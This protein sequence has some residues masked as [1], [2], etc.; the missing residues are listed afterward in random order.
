M[1]WFMTLNLGFSGM[2]NVGLIFAAERPVFLREI[3]NNMYR[4]S[5][6]FWAKILS[7]LPASIIFPTI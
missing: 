2:N 7:E 1:L 3:N 6:Y 4:V 5:S